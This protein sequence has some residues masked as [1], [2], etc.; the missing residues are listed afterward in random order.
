VRF[1]QSERFRGALVSHFGKN[2]EK[3]ERGFGA[4]NEALKRRAESR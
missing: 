2:L 1:G 4:M 3:S